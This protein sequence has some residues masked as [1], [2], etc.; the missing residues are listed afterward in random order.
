MRPSSI[1]HA[2]DTR[3]IE[4]DTFLLADVFQLPLGIGES[5]HIAKTLAKIVC[6]RTTLDWHG[7]IQLE[8]Q[9]NDLRSNL[10]ALGQ[11]SGQTTL[12]DEA[13]GANDV[14]K[15]FDTH[16]DEHTQALA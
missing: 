4:S 8:R 12:P 3:E 14:G 9:P 10:R 2:L 1:W 7:R 6:P 13:P 5:I 16:G 11:G 15:N